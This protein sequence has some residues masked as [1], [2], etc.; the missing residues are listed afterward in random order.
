[1][2]VHQFNKEGISVFTESNL[3]TEFHAHPSLEVIIAKEGTFTLSTK[4]ISLENIQFGFIEPN[5]EH[6]LKAENCTAKIIMIEPGFGVLQQLLQFTDQSDCTG[7]IHT[8]DTDYI[9]DINQETLA[10]WSTD[11]LLM[12]VYDERIL[13]CIHLIT[14][15]QQPKSL[16]LNDLAK[17][18]FLSPDRLSHLFKEQIGIPLQKYMIW[19]RL[20]VAVGLILGQQLNL[21]QAAHTAGFY[22][23][24]H[25]SKHFKEMLGIKPSTVYNS[26]I[27]QD[28]GQQL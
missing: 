1:M 28:S 17:S 27:V 19:N 12:K 25:F 23:S 7:G 20:K 4:A 26:R 11:P 10:I 6:F 14:T 16:S 15:H 8:L 22:D 2:T 24:A 9:S 5:C 13:Q 3:V 21:T 18:V